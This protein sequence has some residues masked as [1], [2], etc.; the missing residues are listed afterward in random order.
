MT[1]KEFN[2]RVQLNGGIDRTIKDWEI[3]DIHVIPEIFTK[4]TEVDF[5]CC[6]GKKVYLLRVRKR[7]G[8][9][10]DIVENPQGLGYPPYLIAEYDFE[11]LNDSTIEKILDEFE[12][13][14][15]K[16]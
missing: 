14:M 6:N 5:Y 10:L 12:D 8:K 2:R 11:I 16:E 4:Q 15:N 3:I 7:H 13:D 1:I 9:K